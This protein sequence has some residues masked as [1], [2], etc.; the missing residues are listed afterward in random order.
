MAVEAAPNTSFD[1]LAAVL[2]GRTDELAAEY[3]RR[4]SIEMPEWTVERP[5]LADALRV[6][7]RESIGNELRALARRAE[8]PAECPPFDADGARYEARLGVPL[9]FVL[10]QYRLGHAIQWEAWFD[11]VEDAEP[12]AAARR[13]LLERGSRFFFEYADRMCRFAT[14]HYTDE[15]EHGLRSTEQRR[16]HLVREVLDGR[17][18]AS[19]ALGYELDGIEHVGVIGW[20]S[21]AADCI[22]G[23]A[24]SLDRRWLVVA[25]AEES[26][27]GWL[28]ARRS[29]GDGA[30]DEQLDRA[31]ARLRPPEGARLAVGA[32][33]GGR[34]G[35]RRTHGQAVAAHRAAA[36]RVDPVVRYEHVALEALAGADAAAAREFAALELRGIDGD[37]VRSE[38]LRETL[39][40]WFESG[41]NAA[42]AAAR[43]GV[44]EQTVAQ[45]LHTALRL[46]RYLAD[47]PG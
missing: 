7:A 37:D 41:L 15:R 32:P 8:L 16:V 45:R 21:G 14:E 1:E 39:S 6:G 28:G 13:Q 43:L 46:R 24:R 19:G 17:D 38:R 26:W 12:G 10:L 5:D 44:H 23:L 33:A 35:F 47:P 42:A 20:G 25:A 29:A 2:V 27:W 36:H 3:V 4:A 11:L 40:A 9:H 30:P 22:R 18:V 31:L 34:D